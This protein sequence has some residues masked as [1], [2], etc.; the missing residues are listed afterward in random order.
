[1]PH[2]DCLR[3]VVEGQ[4]SGEGHIGGQGNDDIGFVAFWC[5]AMS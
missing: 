1:L 4:N 2:N 3:E 5:S